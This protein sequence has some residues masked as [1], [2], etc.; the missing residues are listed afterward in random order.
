[1]S[2]SA[3]TVV[4]QTSGSSGVTLAEQVAAGSYTYTVSGSCKTSFTLT[5]NSP[6]S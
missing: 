3:G 2:T 5:V 6:S 1:M 4:G